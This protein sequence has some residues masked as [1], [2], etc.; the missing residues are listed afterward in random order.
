MILGSVVVVNFVS[1][2][3][4]HETRFTNHEKEEEKR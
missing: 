3:W 1:G 4:D 2:F